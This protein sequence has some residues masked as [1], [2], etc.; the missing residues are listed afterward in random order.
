MTRGIKQ[1]LQDEAQFRSQG[2]GLVSA[3]LPL[4]TLG[5]LVLQLVAGHR[6]V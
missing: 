2:D 1:N 5:D 6:L 4:V 3:G